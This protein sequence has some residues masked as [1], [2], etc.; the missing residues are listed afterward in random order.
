MQY[1]HD[2]CDGC[3]QP[4][5]NDDDIVVCPVCATP[6]HRACY[7]KEGRCVNE[8]K[9]ESGFLWESQGASTAMP[10]TPDDPLVPCPVCGF[11]VAVVLPTLDSY[12]RAE[13]LLG[14]LDGIVFSGGEPS[15][16]LDAIEY[17][18]EVCKKNRIPV[19][20]FYI[21]TNSKMEKEH[22]GRSASVSS[23]ATT[24]TSLPSRPAPSA[25][26]WSRK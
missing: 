10:A 16:N 8:S 22:Q 11:R 24:A 6:Q 25:A 23:R 15:L 5:S 18:L 3:G 17:T 7:E 19:D 21:V 4:F 20:A 1:L 26:R 13:E 12:E 2:H 9:H 14:T